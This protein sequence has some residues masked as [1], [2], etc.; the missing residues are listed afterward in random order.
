MPEWVVDQHVLDRDVTR[1]HFKSNHIFKSL[2]GTS[3]P[4][5]PHA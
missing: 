5:S 1:D 3:A 4:I 2:E